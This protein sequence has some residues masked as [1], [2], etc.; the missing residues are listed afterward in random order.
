MKVLDRRRGM[1]VGVQVASVVGVMIA[2]LLAVVVGVASVRAGRMLGRTIDDGGLGFVESLQVGVAQEIASLRRSNESFVN[3]IVQRLEGKRIFGNEDVV[4]VG[5]RQ[6][7]KIFV[8]DNGLHPIT[9]DQAMVEGW[10]AAMDSQFSIF[11]V[12]EEGLIR[13]ATTLTDQDG[14]LLL[15]G[16][17]E[18]GSTV[19]K[20]TVENRGVYEEIVWLGGQPYAGCYKGVPDVEGNIRMVLFSGTSLKPVEDRVMA[21]SLGEGSYGLVM[22]GEGSIVAHP[23]LEPGVRMKDSAPALWEA[24]VA[25]GVFSSPEPVALEYVFNGRNSRGYIQGIEGVPWFIMV[26]VNADLA[27][28]PVGAMQRGLLLWTLPLAL[29]G[30]ALLTWIVVKLVS[31]LK[32]VVAVADRVAEGD[33]SV[34]VNAVEGSRNEIDRVM[35][36]FGRIIAEYRKLVT[37]VDGMNRQF[38][39]GSRAMSDI[40]DEVH[41]ALGSVEGASKTVADMV[42]SIA[43]SAE[44][45][46][47]GVEEVSSGVASSTQVVT[48]L[49]EKAQ[50][51]SENAVQGR[52]AVDDVTSGTAG[53]GEATSRV[54]NAI[55]ELERSVGGITGFVNTIV[56]IADQTNLLALNAAI[57]AARAGEAGRGFAVVAEEVRKLAEE[58]N[59]AASSI[60]NVI[61]KVQQDMLVAAKDTKEAGAMMEDLLRRS[62]QA[63]SE[64]RDAADGVASMAEGIQSIAAASQEQSASTQEIAKSVDGIASMLNNGSESAK[65]MRTAG[66]VMAQK[67]K[68]LESIR[69]GQE[70]RLEELK[71]LTS[72]YRLK[73]EKGLAEL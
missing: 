22:D 44:E 48:E 34:E 12:T 28:A 61:D 17:F 60:K 36:A 23:K 70:R 62:D 10:Q 19:Y 29:L 8:M 55:D 72:G 26:V 40:A 16:L 64:I 73:S 42:E 56:T 46:N 54:V 32:K 67:L 45:T 53:A 18:K 13:V 7:S 33:L 37:K 2:L 66:E 68:E 50:S 39:Q 58:S 24:C 20:N 38:A 1:S 49:S 71:E 43:S 35:V 4:Q 25:S 41:R 63:A 3:I 11:Q 52:K 47:A 14:K 30:L 15:G 31:P 59:N 57:E 69:K 21:A 51:V 65:E 27:L 6:V 5:D 9:G